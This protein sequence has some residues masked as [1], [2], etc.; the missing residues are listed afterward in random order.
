MS[1][2]R[3]ATALKINPKGLVS[4]TVCRGQLGQLRQSGQLRQ[5]GQL[6]QLI[7][8]G[9]LELFIS[10]VFWGFGGCGVLQAAGR[11][12]FLYFCGNVNPESDPEVFAGEI[13]A[14][15]RLI[16]LHIKY[17]SRVSEAMY[18][19]IFSFIEP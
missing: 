10:T 3:A 13:Q 6:G 12:C 17:S 4:K 9:R 1:M 11:R 19:S 18:I 16:S 5:L 15:A 7:Q 14:M 8:L 2:P